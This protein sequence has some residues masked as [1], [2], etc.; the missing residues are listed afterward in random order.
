MYNWPDSCL[1]CA[2]SG[3]SAPTSKD[4]TNCG[5]STHWTTAGSA[6][7]PSASRRELA[8]DRRFFLG[9]QVIEIL[10]GEM[11]LRPHH[12]PEIS[13]MTREVAAHQN[14]TGN[15][16]DAVVE[17]AQIGATLQ[18]RSAGRRLHSATTDA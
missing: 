8:R 10:D 6:G 16:A 9:R 3:V 14:I 2:C 18:A 11:K 12:D 1:P 17:A 7:A 5:F 15:E 4:L 13:H